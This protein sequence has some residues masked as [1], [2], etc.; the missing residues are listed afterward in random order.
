VVIITE[1]QVSVLK[2]VIRELRTTETDIVAVVL[3]PSRKIRRQC[4]KPSRTLICGLQSQ[5]LNVENASAA[6]NIGLRNSE[7]GGE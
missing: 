6:V 2:P 1:L 5:N 4:L 3:S 7:T